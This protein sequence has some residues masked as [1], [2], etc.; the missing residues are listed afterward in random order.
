QDAKT[1]RSSERPHPSKT[2]SSGAP[3]R[4]FEAEP[5][6][7]ANPLSEEAGY[8]RTSL[9][10]GLLNLVSYN[11][12]RGATTVRLFES[13]EVFAKAGDS[14][15]ERRRLGIVATGDA[16]PGSVHS[17][18]QPYTFFHIKGDLEQV[19]AAFE[20]QS[21]QYD[22]NVPAFL[23]P[24]RSARAIMDGETV[25][26]FGQL[27]PETAATRKI[28]QDVY[29]AEVML[30]GLYRHALREPRYQRISKFPA[31]ER[32]FSFIFDDAVTFE[33]IQSA[34]KELGIAE[35]KTLE[36]R[37]IFRGEKVG[38]GKYSVLLH[39]EFQ[40]QERTLRDE[41]VAQWSAQIIAKLESL[42]GV[43]RAQ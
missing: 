27:H 20:H 35:L 38:A 30:D 26:V 14:C 7:L 42:G 23:H 4:V 18:A 8:M 32:D 39:A 34:V 16:L 11:L 43:L 9:L 37:E 25:A 31:V 12:N 19:L 36:P 22:A 10:P 33:R 15:D 2:G 3:S 21:L 1:F 41:E 17:P 5:L 13:G 40:S 6:A 29:L 24:G 28:K